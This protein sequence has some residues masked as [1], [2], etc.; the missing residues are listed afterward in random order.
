MINLHELTNGLEKYYSPEFNREIVSK[1][2][3]KD[4]GYYQSLGEVVDI[5]SSVDHYKTSRLAQYHIRRRQDSLAD[6]I[7]FYQYL[8]DNFY[9]IACRRENVFEHALSWALNV[10]TKKLN[11]YHTNEKCD[12]FLDMYHTPIDVDVT[13]F[14]AALDDYRL[15]L[16]WCRD[17][18]GVARYFN[19]EQHLPHI[20]RFILELPIFAGQPQ[21]ISWQDQFGIDFQDWN[22]CHALKGDLGSIAFERP[23]MLLQLQ[24]QRHTT[25]TDLV[26]AYQRWALPHWPAISNAQD[27]EALPAEIKSRFEIMPKNHYDVIS[28]LGS[29]ERG[30]LAQHASGYQ[31][32]NSAIQRMQDLDIIVSPPPMKKHTLR[33]KRH[34]IRNFDQCLAHYNHWVSEYPEVGQPLSDH[35]VDQQCQEEYARWHD[36]SA[37]RSRSDQLGSA[38]LQYQ[39]ESRPWRD[40]VARPVSPAVD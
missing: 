22:R 35:T 30:Y 14:A 27:F 10:I 18:F 1:R 40:P 24:A 38:Q 21:R 4:W 32:A 25:D 26:S 15:Y 29:A 11:V 39:N 19:Y 6:Q 20:E 37:G 7:P 16:Q 5:L 34:L 12:T 31:A 13:A 3:V 23:E 2:R 28:C 33:E 8:N 17:H 9:I 36:V